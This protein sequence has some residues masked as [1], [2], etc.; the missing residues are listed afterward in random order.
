MPL[1]QGDNSRTIGIISNV[2]RFEIREHLP[3]H[4]HL[5]VANHPAEIQSDQADARHTARYQQ[6]VAQR[7]RRMSGLVNQFRWAAG[8]RVRALSHRLHLCPLRHRPLKTGGR[9]SLKART[10]SSR[11]SVGT[12]RL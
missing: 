7:G 3:H 8:E 11:S 2:F 10:P 6:L 4:I 5:A 12:I 1:A 9:F